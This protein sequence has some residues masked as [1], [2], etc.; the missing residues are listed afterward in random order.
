[1]KKKGGIIAETACIQV[2]R[3]SVVYTSHLIIDG[4]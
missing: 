3:H 2:K 1:M 4:F